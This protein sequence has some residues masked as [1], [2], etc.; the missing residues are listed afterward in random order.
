MVEV[1]GGEGGFEAGWKT[2]AAI[3]NFDGVHL[4]HQYLIDQVK[5]HAEQANAKTAIVLFA[6][7]PRVFFR[8]DDPAFLIMSPDNRDAV[9]FHHGVEII[10]SLP[11]DETMANMPAEDFIK[12]VL[13]DELSLSGILVGQDFRFGKDRLADGAFLEK[14]GAELGLKVVL[15][16]TISSSSSTLP[17]HP[18]IG[19]SAIRQAIREG[20]MAHAQKMLGRPWDFVG[21]V[22]KGQQLGRTIGFPTAN[23]RM[24][25]V[26][27]PRHGVYAVQ[28]ELEEKSFQ[29]VANFGRRPTLGAGDPLL[30]VHLFDFEEEIY[31]KRLIVQFFDFIREEQKFDSLDALKA[32]IT[33]DCA[34][35]RQLLTKP[36]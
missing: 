29:G 23:L 24:G 14:M 25:D 28:V 36:H 33:K 8:P 7:H 22:E 19:S 3:G 17:E 30:E 6:P 26:M 31:G 1:N 16:Q 13:I 27:A 21:I 12:D 34:Q 4:G 10:H 15:A 2:F 20:Q 18:K 32:Q 5:N 9:L 35:V 11:F